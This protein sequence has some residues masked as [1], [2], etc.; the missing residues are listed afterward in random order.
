MIAFPLALLLAAL[1]LRVLRLAWSGG[2]I[3]HYMVGLYFLAM[4]VGAPPALLAGDPGAVP[5]HLATFAMAGGHAVLSLGFGALAVFAWTC[6]GPTSF[7]RQLLALGLCGSLVALW[8]A[9]GVI[10]R[11]A[12]PG[13]VVVRAAALTR[14]AVLAWAFGE[15]L[16]YHVLMRRRVAVGIADPVVAN[17]FLLWAFWTG[18]MLA[19]I[20]VAIAVRFLIPDFGIAATAEQ[21]A[22]VVSAVAGTASLSA[23]ALWLA[24]FPP[25]A[26][27]AWIERSSQR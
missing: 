12:P 2:A 10:E 27:V 14:S 13:D 25:R 16:R 23:L 24:F 15:S 7:W 19:A 8:I 18:G 9:Q 1:G 17:R 22:L 4:G 20:G 21:R 5:P 3:P 11:F 26:Y 6:F